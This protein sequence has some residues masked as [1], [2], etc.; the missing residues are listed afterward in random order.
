VP[1]PSTKLS[2]WLREGSAAS[3]SSSN[4]DSENVATML[5]ALS[6][7]GRQQQAQVDHLEAIAAGLRHEVAARE[8][9]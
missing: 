4:P 3:A 1:S 2:S 9:R 8:G 6:V 7:P 5:P